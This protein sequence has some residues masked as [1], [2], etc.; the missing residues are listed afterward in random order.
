M[1]GGLW[2]DGPGLAPGP[3]RGVGGGRGWRRGMGAG[4]A[5]TRFGRGGAW[6]LG[7]GRWAAGCPGARVP[8]CRGARVPGCPDLGV[9]SHFAPD[10]SFAAKRVRE[11]VH[12]GALMF[13]LRVGPVG[14]GEACTK[15]SP[16]PRPLRTFDDATHF[17]GATSIGREVWR[18]R[19]RTR[20]SK[21]TWAAMTE[22]PGRGRRGQRAAIAR[23]RQAGAEGSPGPR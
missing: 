16:A 21:L 5:A 3:G 11:I 6:A 23:P 18:A 1:G 12:L 9:C 4:G 14:G 19:L 8:G 22:V 2:G 10:P 13:T 15:C 17:S 7:G 20:A